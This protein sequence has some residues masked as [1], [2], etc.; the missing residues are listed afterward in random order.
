MN[1]TQVARCVLASALIFAACGDDQ[2]TTTAEELQAASVYHDA[3]VVSAL[4]AGNYAIS[5]VAQGAT[6]AFASATDGGAVVD[7]GAAVLATQQQTDADAALVR[8]Y[9]TADVN[10]ADGSTPGNL[11]A[12]VGTLTSNPLTDAIN[13]QATSDAVTV[14]GSDTPDVDYASVALAEDQALLDIITA[15]LDPA[16]GAYAITS[17]DLK[18]ELAAEQ[19]S[20]QADLDA[21]QAEIDTLSA[22]AD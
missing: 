12:S 10:P 5:Q 20:L 9:G 19:T 13:A 11:A 22:D 6:D 7:P 17:D 18:A 2:A 8:L 1:P 4:V 21:A 3:D 16:N 14:G 15:A